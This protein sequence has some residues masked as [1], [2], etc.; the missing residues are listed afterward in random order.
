MESR[1][2]RTVGNLGTGTMGFGTAFLFALKGYE[3]RMFGRSE[4]SLERGFSSIRQALH[5]YE[6]NGLTSPE[7]REAILGRI[8]GCTALEEAVQDADFI[9]ESIAEDLQVKQ[10]VWGRVEK[11]A[12]TDAIFATNTSGLS[13]TRIAQNL[14]NPE[15]FIVAHFWNPPHL[16]PLVEVVPGRQTAPE[17]VERTWQLMQ[18]IGKKPVRLQ[19]EAPGFIGNRL[20]FALLREALHIVEDGIASAEAVD[21]AVR[22]SFGRRLAATGPLESADLGGLDIFYNI[23]SYLN[24][25][26]CSR[27][28][29]SALL[30]DCVQRQDLGAKTGQGLYA[31]KAAELEQLKQDRE[32]TLLHWLRR[33]QQQGEIP[34]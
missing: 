21:M 7:Q 25:E 14:Q 11:A 24:T 23:S 22:Y 13:P 32:E 9:I 29:V 15:R 17:V 6:E 12:R 26:L 10:E 1:K 28:D 18:Q 27:A 4:T 34:K 16:L 19:R 3:V 8:M 5:M 30:A 2:I 31:W 33:D 20:Q